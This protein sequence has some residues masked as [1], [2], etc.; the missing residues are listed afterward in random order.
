M[1]EDADNAEQPV[2]SLLVD[3]VQLLT[4]EEAEAMKTRLTLKCCTLQ[5]SLDRFPERESKSLGAPKRTLP[6]LWHA[7]HWAAAQQDQRFQIMRHRL[8]R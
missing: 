7:G 8:E 3:N 5:R 6:K 4:P 2:K 1:D